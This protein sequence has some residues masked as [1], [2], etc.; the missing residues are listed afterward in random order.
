MA[1]LHAK[2]DSSFSEHNLQYKYVAAEELSKSS[3]QSFD[4]VCAME[5][6]EHVDKPADFLRT[7]SDL[8]KVGIMLVDLPINDDLCS[9][10]DICSFRQFH[11]H[12]YQNS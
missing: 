9:Q 4:L 10:V 12:R 8:V 5:V 2:Q 6:V 1:E 3:K 7:C 11:A